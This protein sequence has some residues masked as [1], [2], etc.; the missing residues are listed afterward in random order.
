MWLS[1]S[2]GIVKT[3]KL[4]VYFIT[5]ETGEEHFLKSNRIV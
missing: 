3:I 5:E 2:I 4:F 1:M